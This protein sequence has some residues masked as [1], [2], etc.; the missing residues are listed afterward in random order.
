MIIML[1]R[2]TLILSLASGLAMAGGMLVEEPEDISTPPIDPVK[3]GVRWHAG[4]HSGLTEKDREVIRERRKQVE[5]MAKRIREK[6]EALEQSGGEDKER[7]TRELKHL[8]LDGDKDLNK[9]EELSEK[10]IQKKEEIR[11]K[12]LERARQK[13]EHQG[14]HGDGNGS[15]GKGPQPQDD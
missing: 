5:E 12:R 10:Q 13:A 6:R 7:H 4:D 3:E 1:K 15:H 11:E 14:N 2:L 8:I 9:K